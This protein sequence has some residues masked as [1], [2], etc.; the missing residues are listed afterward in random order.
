MNFK[1]TYKDEDYSKEWDVVAD[2][3]AAAIL[4]VLNTKYSDRS[5]EDLN[6]L[7]EHMSAKEVKA[8]AK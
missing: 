1:V 6:F 8:K 2:N 3:G 7:A 5:E 4:E